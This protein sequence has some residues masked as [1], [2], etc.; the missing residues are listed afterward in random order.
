MQQLR[1][2]FYLSQ[3]FSTA[4]ERY[5]F[6]ACCACLSVLAAIRDEGV[7]P[8][9]VACNY[10]P[11]ELLLRPALVALQVSPACTE[12]MHLLGSMVLFCQ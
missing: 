8:I 2:Y 11:E 12:L 3:E 10:R 1:C 4:M 9:T 7:S 5:V 6:W